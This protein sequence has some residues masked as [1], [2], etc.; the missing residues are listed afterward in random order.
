MAGRRCSSEQRGLIPIFLL[1]G[2]AKW[3][4]DP[5]S[6]SLRAGAGALSKA[7]RTNILSVRFPE[8][9]FC[10]SLLHFSNVCYIF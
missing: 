8:L 6:G 1:G 2:K 3:A 4:G 9:T 7:N 5:F 10:K